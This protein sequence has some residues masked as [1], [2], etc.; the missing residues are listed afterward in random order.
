MPPGRAPSPA[1]PPS[2]VRRFDPWETL[3]FSSE[4]C[5]ILPLVYEEDRWPTTRRFISI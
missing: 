1:M 5:V 4:L 3:R 2:V